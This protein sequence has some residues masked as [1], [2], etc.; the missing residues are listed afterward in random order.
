MLLIMLHAFKIFSQDCEWDSIQI[1]QDNRVTLL[2]S[3]LFGIW[4]FVPEKSKT[5]D[6][7]FPGDSS[8]HPVLLTIKPDSIFISSFIILRDSYCKTI[9]LAEY[10]LQN[11]QLRVN[12]VQRFF[13][14]KDGGRP[15][16]DKELFFSD[17]FAVKMLDEKALCL[18]SRKL[19]AKLY[20]G[21]IVEKYYFKIIN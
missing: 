14:C 6:P 2:K 15:V 21:L 3:Q 10:Y 20:D 13:D 19:Y 1:A 12:G 8:V 9:I 18:Y 5:D 16:K 11:N 7:S 17:C 4:K